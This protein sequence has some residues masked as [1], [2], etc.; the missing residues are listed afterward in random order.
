MELYAIFRHPEAGCD[1]DTED[2]KQAGFVVGE[3]YRV[4]HLWVGTWRSFVELVGF[5]GDF[6]S[7]HFLFVDRDGNE[8]NVYTDPKYRYF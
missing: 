1:E 6:N 2:V 5:D 7:A 8:V 3:R 4:A